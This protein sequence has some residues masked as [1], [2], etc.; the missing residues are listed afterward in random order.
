MRS[1][2]VCDFLSTMDERI[3]SIY[4]EVIMLNYISSSS[5]GSIILSRKKCRCNCLGFPWM[6]EYTRNRNINVFGIARSLGGFLATFFPYSQPQ[7]KKSCAIFA[8]HEVAAKCRTNRSAQLSATCRSSLFVIMLSKTV[9]YDDTQLFWC[10]CFSVEKFNLDLQ[11]H[12]NILTFTLLKNC[13]DTDNICYALLQ[14]GSVD[15]ISHTE[16]MQKQDVWIL[17][18]PL[19]SATLPTKRLCE[20]RQFHN[21]AIQCKFDAIEE[22]FP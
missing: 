4:I 13:V 6:K 7:L 22:D 9:C 10:C 11:K 17:V 19:N 8:G 18:R 15:S 21:L 12:R 5:D 2:C 14:Y 16:K 20:M 3:D 1:L